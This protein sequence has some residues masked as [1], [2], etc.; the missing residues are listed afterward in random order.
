M[1][2]PVKGMDTDRKHE[3]DVD[4]YITERHK[5]EYEQYKEAR[6]KRL[7]RIKFSM[8]CIPQS[9]ML[10]PSSLK[11]EIHDESVRISITPEADLAGGVRRC[12]VIDGKRLSFVVI[13][14]GPKIYIGSSRGD[15]S[16]YCQGANGTYLATQRRQSADLGRRVERKRNRG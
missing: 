8:I 12:F 13:H 15:P 7:R 3:G 16:G 1:P 9:T 5:K 10:G 2:D 4:Q 14:R 11:A 6:I